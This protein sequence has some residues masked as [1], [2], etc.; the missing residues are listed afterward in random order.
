MPSEN[1]SEKLI[2]E[3]RTWIG[4]PYVP[5]GRVKGVGADCGGILYELYNPEF[6]P[7]APYPEYPPDWAMH[8]DTERYLDFIMP[9]VVQVPQA[10]IGGFS[11]FHIGLAHAHAAILVDKNEYLHAWGR[12]RAGSVTTSKPRQIAALIRLYGGK[13][14]K[15]FWPKGA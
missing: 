9:Y 12:L 7:F 2:K 3:A 6:G 13:P 11:L 10:R 15:H 8:A 1:W 5:R 4:T 14:P